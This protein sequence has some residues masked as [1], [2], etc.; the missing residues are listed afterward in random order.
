MRPPKVIRHWVTVLLIAALLTGCWDRSELEENAFVL[1]LGVDRGENSHYSVTM[2]MALPEPLVGEDGGNGSPL[3]LTTIEAPTLVGAMGLLD[4]LYNRR[5]SLLHTTVI[6]LSEELARESGLH[7][8]D[9]LS[10][11]RQ[12]RQTIY[13]LVT[14]GSAAD[15]L[16]AMEPGMERNPQR[17][18]EQI[19]HNARFTGLIPRESQIHT[20]L[21]EVNTGY[22]QPIVYYAAL[23]ESAQEGGTAGESAGDGQ[24]R[25]RGESGFES[26]QLPRQG[27]PNIEMIGAAA[28][29]GERM[30]GVLTGDEVRL[31]LMMRDQFVRG[32]FTVPD[33]RAPDQ[34]VSL[35]LRRGRPYR[36][37]VDLSGDRPRVNGLITLEGDLLGIQSHVDYTEP[38]L[39]LELQEAIS[40]HFQEHIVT[41]MDKT[42][43]W[44]ADV[45]G[46]GAHAVRQFPTV[47]DWEAYA[48]AQ[49]YEQAAIDIE[50]RVTLRRYG[51][52]L[53]PP[54]AVE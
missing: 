45:A 29:R 13:Y 42:Q 36:V 35:D 32:L 39:E 52:T 47:A 26:G 44:G 25:G 17:Y 3:L 23:V 14:K 12:S 18:L 37:Q 33:P 4:G 40:K 20:Y 43:E 54:Q 50:V 53:S 9:E 41:L 11:F 34:F 49:R 7:T 51:T 5:V 46:I 1:M 28:F 21:T 27:G 2:A 22:R 19:A 48:W 10:R 6:L 24:Q 8:M 16:R 15:F 30:V 31:L 38:E